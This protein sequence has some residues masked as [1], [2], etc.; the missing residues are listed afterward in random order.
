MFIMIQDIVNN[1]T[2]GP[3]A[4]LKVFVMTNLQ[5]GLNFMLLSQSKIH[6]CQPVVDKGK[7][8]FHIFWIFIK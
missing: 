3:V 6:F 4:K 7:F 1:C 8:L 2:L 5:L